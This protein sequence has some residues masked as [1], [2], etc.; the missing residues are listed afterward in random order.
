MV[1]A[2]IFVTRPRIN[3]PCLSCQLYPLLEGGRDELVAEYALQDS[4]QRYKSQMLSMRYKMDLR[5]GHVLLGGG[6]VDGL[7]VVDTGQLL[8]AARE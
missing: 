4:E 5:A 1:V 3:P 7:V 6:D 8:Q 2:A